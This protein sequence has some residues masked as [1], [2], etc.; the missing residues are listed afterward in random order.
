MQVKRVEFGSGD[1]SV[2]YIPA[3]QVSSS[4]EE[5]AVSQS[6]Q[7]RDSALGPD[8]VQ[9]EETDLPPPAN[10]PLAYGCL[11]VGRDT[12]VTGSLSV[13]GTLRVE[14]RVD[15]EIEA[16]EIIV[17]SGGTVVGNVSCEMGTIHGT[18]SGTLWCSDKLVIRAGATLE[19]DLTYHK[20]FRAEAGALLNCNLLYRNEPAPAPIHRAVT[21]DREEIRYVE[22]HTQQ[23]TSLM[24][25][26]F[27]TEKHP[28]G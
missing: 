25:R 22:E 14:G 10:E 8:T 5:S 23:R 19:G 27:G 20:D 3:P 21:F 24:T 16:A 28:R 26:L 15:G 1:T 4:A 6:P 9:L 11:V 13:P 17:L 2:A 7:S 12:H 18:L